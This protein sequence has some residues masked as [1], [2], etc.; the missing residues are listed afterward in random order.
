MRWIMV[1]SGRKDGLGPGP[2]PGAG[3]DVGAGG[4]K[5][6]IRLPRRIGTRSFTGLDGR[7][8]RAL[9]LVDT[10][11][12]GLRISRRGNSSERGRKS[13][14]GDLGR[15]TRL[16]RETPRRRK[17]RASGGDGARRGGFIVGPSHL[18]SSLYRGT[19]GRVY[20][21]RSRDG[22]RRGRSSS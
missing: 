15:T 20:M 21:Y 3:R 2:R 10:D 12:C 16:G 13:G 19:T 14:S 1:T 6:E 22:I 5:G 9:G 17:V 11:P 4:G 7:A 18:Y 8:G